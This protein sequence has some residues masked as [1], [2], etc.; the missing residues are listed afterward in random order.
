MSPGERTVHVRVTWGDYVGPAPADYPHF[1]YIFARRSLGSAE[2]MEV[3]TQR[4]S[5]DPRYVCGKLALRAMKLVARA[6]P[7]GSGAAAPQ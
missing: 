5:K 7:A 6:L 1:G 2:P 3:R 4:L